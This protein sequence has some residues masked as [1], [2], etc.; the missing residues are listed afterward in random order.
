M[1]EQT[2]TMNATEQKIAAATNP[3]QRAVTAQPY[4]NPEQHKGATLGQVEEC[5]FC[6]H[7]ICFICFGP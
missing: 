2:V 5:D 7:A 4:R 6:Q 1:T 3:Q